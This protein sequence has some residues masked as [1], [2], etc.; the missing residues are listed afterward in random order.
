MITKSL[1]KGLEPSF[2]R[3]KHNQQQL[4][5]KVN[6]LVVASLGSSWQEIFAYI[7]MYCNLCCN[8]A[9]DNH[10]VNSLATTKDIYIL[11]KDLDSTVA[12]SEIDSVL[13]F[14]E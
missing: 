3:F 9:T 11:I 5:G 8:R 13:T 7:K 14:I 6:H 12:T 10:C 4:Y 1:R 2:V